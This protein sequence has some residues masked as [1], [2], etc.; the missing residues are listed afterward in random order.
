MSQT[1]TRYACNTTNNNSAIDISLDWKAQLQSVAQFAFV[2]KGL[3]LPSKLVK[4]DRLKFVCCRL[5]VFIETIWDVQ[6]GKWCEKCENPKSESE[7]V[8]SIERINGSKVE[9]TCSRS[10]RAIL[11]VT[12]IRKFHSCEL[13]VIE[14]Q[15][16]SIQKGQKQKALLEL[17]QAK[18]LEAQQRCLKVIVRV[19]EVFGNSKLLTSNLLQSLYAKISLEISEEEEPLKIICPY[20][21][22]SHSA[23]CKEIIRCFDQDNRRRTFRLLCLLL[24][25]DKNSHLLAKKAFVAMLEIFKGL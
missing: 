15:Q 17:A 22:L 18:M 10:H 4:P 24:H 8:Y 9:F 1:D 6:K 7:K 12:E 11:S 20:L 25:P 23:V 19:K 2:H 16:I 5:H 21:L 3:F 13:C 14:L